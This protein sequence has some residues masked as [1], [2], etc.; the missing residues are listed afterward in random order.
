LLVYG[1]SGAY[2]HPDI[3]RV[4][5]Q[6]HVAGFR[7]TPGG[8]KFVRYL[9]PGSPGE[10]RV[11]RDLEPDERVYGASIAA[12]AVPPRQFAQ[13][14]NTLRQ[15]ALDAPH[16]AGIP[17][18]F[19]LDCEGNQSLDYYTMGMSGFPHPMGLVQ[20]GDPTLCR[21]V[22]RAIGQQLAAV[23]LIPLQF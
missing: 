23:G 13:V 14:L 5:D 2:P 7:I 10:K 20:S 22:A 15:C 21:R 12:P 17:L 1:F 4:I 11:V 3:L 16:G 6:Y 8:R 9:K 19:A 18:Y